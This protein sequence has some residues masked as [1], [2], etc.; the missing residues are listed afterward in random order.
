MNEVGSA[1]FRMISLPGVEGACV[2]RA[3][4]VFLAVAVS[5]ST[6]AAA[7]TDPGA[8]ATALSNRPSPKA[9]CRNDDPK[10]VVVCGRSQQ[11]FRIDPGVLA[12]IRAAETPPP[13][14]PLDATS[15]Q[16][17]TGSQCGGGNYA[18][19]VGMA[20]KALKAAELAANGD[21]WKEAFRTRPDQYQAYRAEQTKKPGVSVG[22]TV[23]NH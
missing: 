4:C 9:E 19:L 12:G 11:R 17:C 23:G 14:P 22:V 16:P 21:D 20:L 6:G 10:S 15:G 5:A 1:G 3:F 13:K 8:V 2:T 18:P 7:Q